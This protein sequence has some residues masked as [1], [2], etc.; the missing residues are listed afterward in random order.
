MGA[1]ISAIVLSGFLV[2]YLL[3]NG[4]Y[5]LRLSLQALT[6]AQAGVE[7]SVLKLIRNNQ[8]IIICSL[9]S[10]NLSLTNNSKACVTIGGD[11]PVASNIV[12]KKI[13]SQGFA[14]TRYRQLEALVQID[15]NLGT[16]QTLSIQ[17]TAIP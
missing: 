5:G 14:A 9:P 2:I 4:N 1:V 12:Q 7:D 10:Y 11:I 8:I 15:R 17:E 6:A 13:V 3:A 16:V